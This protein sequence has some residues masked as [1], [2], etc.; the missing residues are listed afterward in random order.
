M[1]LAQIPSRREFYNAGMGLEAMHLNHIAS[2][3]IFLATVLLSMID[4]NLFV[5]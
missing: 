3:I 1:Y 4:T 5:D 2:G